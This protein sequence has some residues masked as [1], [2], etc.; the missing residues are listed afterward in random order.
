MSLNG[1]SNILSILKKIE[2]LENKIEQLEIKNKN[3]S[4]ALE[5]KVRFLTQNSFGDPN[6]SLYT[7]DNVTY[8]L[9]L[10]FTVN[11][12]SK[13]INLGNFKM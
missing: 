4:V 6:L 5:K 3:M 2:D 1:N 11:G 13:Y 8:Y 9:Q 10:Y 7:A 12:T